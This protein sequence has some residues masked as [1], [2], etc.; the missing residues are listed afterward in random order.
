MPSTGRRE[1]W[2]ASEERMQWLVGSGQ[3]WG[4]LVRTG[5]GWE[6]H[7]ADLFLG[8]RVI[9]CGNYNVSYDRRDF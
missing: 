8:A 3:G 9:E 6:R 2:E 7:A 5:C 4:G 1:E